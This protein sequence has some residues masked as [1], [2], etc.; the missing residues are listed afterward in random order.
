MSDQFNVGDVVH[1][2]SNPDPK[3]TIIGIRDDVAELA[4]FFESLK[5]TEDDIPLAALRKVNDE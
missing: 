2:A 1:L 3:M 4:W 5:L